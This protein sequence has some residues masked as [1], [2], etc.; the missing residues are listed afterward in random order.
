MTWVIE[1][2]QFD[3]KYEPRTAIK[4]Q[5]L[6]DFISKTS[7]LAVDLDS[8]TWMLHVDGSS[9]NKGSGA[10]II[11]ESSTGLILEQSLRFKFPA[12]NNQAEYEA[13]IAGMKI[14]KEI[15][16]ENLII[17]SDSQLMISQVKGKYQA[18]ELTL[19]QYLKKVKDADVLSR[20]ASIKKPGNNRS[21]IQS[22]L[23]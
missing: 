10:D 1:L 13:C 17:C 20:L 23:S 8:L 12:S 21:I 6:A 11:L 7:D 19:Q 3:I 9:N 5:V 4:A 14:A 16:A 18:R 22:T 15:R 2:S